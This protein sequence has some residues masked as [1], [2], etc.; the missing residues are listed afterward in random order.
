MEA[1]NL[2]KPA[3]SDDI[4]QS[5]RHIRELTKVCERETQEVILSRTRTSPNAEFC[6]HQEADPALSYTPSLRG[7]TAK[8]SGA[9]VLQLSVACQS[10]IQGDGKMNDRGGSGANEHRVPSRMPVSD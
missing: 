1:S 4:V 3:S 2:T 9:R 7:S 6:A 10:D 5:R 8:L